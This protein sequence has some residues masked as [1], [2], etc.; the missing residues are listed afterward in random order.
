MLVVEKK[1]GTREL[2]NDFSGPDTGRAVTPEVWSASVGVPKE[3]LLSY[4]EVPC[5]TRL[6]R[7]AA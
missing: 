7:I 3:E 5:R 6:K 4:P 2:L 1:V